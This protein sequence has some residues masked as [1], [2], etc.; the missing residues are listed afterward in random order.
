LHLTVR[1]VLLLCT[2]HI[3]HCLYCVL[4]ALVNLL[5]KKMMMMMMVVVRPKRRH[6]WMATTKTATVFEYSVGVTVIML[7]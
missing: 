1:A 3:V 6:T 7:C 5:L 4:V 2:S